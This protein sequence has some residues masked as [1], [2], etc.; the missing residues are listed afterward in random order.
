MRPKT[1]SD[2]NK[3]KSLLTGIMTIW[4]FKSC[5]IPSNYNIKSH[6]QSNVTRIKLNLS[7]LIIWQ[8][9]HSNVSR[10]DFWIKFTITS[11]Q[12]KNNVKVSRTVIVYVSIGGKTE[13]LEGTCWV[14]NDLHVF[15]VTSSPSCWN[16]LCVE[17]QMRMRTIFHVKLQKQRLE[18]CICIWMT[19]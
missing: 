12:I 6:K 10:M 5:H 1:G 4:T 3:Q 11:D 8:I 2:Y 19:I 16:L 15:R 17:L 18:T 13:I 14:Y 7:D 9:V